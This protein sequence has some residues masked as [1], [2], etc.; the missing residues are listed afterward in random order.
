MRSP[1]WFMNLAFHIKGVERFPYFDAKILFVQQRFLDTGITVSNVIH[2]NFSKIDTDSG[3]TT[4]Q[5][6]SIEDY[7]K[8]KVTE[9]QYESIFYA[10]SHRINVLCLIA[11]QCQIGTNITDFSSQPHWEPSLP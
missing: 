9:F 8:F 4:V 6:K 11:E 2:K 3:T 1:E 10:Y 7:M 5:S